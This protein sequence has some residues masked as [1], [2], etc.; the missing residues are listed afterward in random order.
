MP[1][2]TATH[3]SKNSLK[4]LQNMLDLSEDA[5]VCTGTQ[6]E[7]ILMNHKTQSLPGLWDSVSSKQLWDHFITADSK[8][9]YLS[10]HP[11]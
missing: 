2:Q 3:E 4:F 6:Q 9:D 8:K 7:I 1:T 10:V 11:E 5:I